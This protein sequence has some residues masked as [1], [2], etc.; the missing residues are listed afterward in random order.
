MVVADLASADK[1]RFRILKSVL[2][3]SDATC[4]T[5]RVSVR[6]FVALPVAYTLHMRAGQGMNKMYRD[7]SRTSVVVGRVTPGQI[8]TAEQDIYNWIK[9]EGGGWLPKANKVLRWVVGCYFK[10]ANVHPIA[11]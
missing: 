5:Q 7:R 6:G 9:I 11:R 1:A 3:V 10:F 4:S 2:S 8:V